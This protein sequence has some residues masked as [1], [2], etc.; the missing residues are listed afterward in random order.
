MYTP[1]SVVYHLETQSRKAQLRAVEEYRALMYLRA[2]HPD[3]FERS[4]DPYYHPSLDPDGLNRLQIRA[5][6]Q[7]LTDLYLRGIYREGDEAE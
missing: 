5:S 7:E 1:F 3:V 2:K 4:A 6:A